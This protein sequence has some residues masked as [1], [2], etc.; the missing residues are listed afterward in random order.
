MNRNALTEQRRETVIGLLKGMNIKKSTVGGFDKDDVYEC[1]QQL[2]DLYEK[3]IEELE[4]AYEGEINTLRER[5]Q[6]YDD[7]N[8][9]YVSL[10]M[11]AKKSSNDIINQA[12]SEVEII[13]AEGKEE[14]AKQEKELEQVRYN[15]DAEKNAIIAEL[16]ASREAVEA[17]KAAMKAEV[18]AEREKLTAL[19]NKYRQQINSMEEEFADIKTNILRTSGKI[20]SLKSKLPAD[21]EEINW[22][23]SNDVDAVDFPAEDVAVEDIIIPAEEIV[24][25]AVEGEVEVPANNDT[26]EEAVSLDD[27]MPV[28]DPIAELPE[29]EEPAVEEI[30]LDEFEIEEFVIED[31]PAVE[32]MAEEEPV[33]ELTLEDLMAEIPEE[34][35]QEAAPEEFTLEDIEID[36]SEFEVAPDATQEISFDGLEDLFKEEK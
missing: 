31:V 21:D 36:L 34:P 4:N 15:M 10:I 17:E 19:K 2:C 35:A 22:N 18:D 16:N 28:E 14:I 11:E 12:K 20:D 3:N 5:Y 23:V 9:L 32:P 27:L 25:E 30:S 1:M 8:E 24:I 7:N 26:V 13:L 33:A 6:K 29:V